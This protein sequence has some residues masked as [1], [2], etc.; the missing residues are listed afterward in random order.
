MGRNIKIQVCW[1]SV[2][3]NSHLVCVYKVDCQN[4]FLT[5]PS[6]SDLETQMSSVYV[7]VNYFGIINFYIVIV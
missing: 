4:I 5:N 2:L 7:F 6:S 1:L 3:D